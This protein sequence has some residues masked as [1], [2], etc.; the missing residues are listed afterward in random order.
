MAKRLSPKQA[1]TLGQVCSLNRDNTYAG[2]YWLMTSGDDVTICHQ[3]VGQ[4]PVG[5]VTIPRELF[6]RFINWY[7]RPQKVTP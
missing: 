5:S 4:N 6:I 7:Q 1:R 3:A 2:D